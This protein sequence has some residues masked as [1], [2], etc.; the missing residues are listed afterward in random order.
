MEFK[1]KVQEEAYKKIEQWLPMTVGEDRMGKYG[2]DGFWFIEGS[3][4]VYVRVL[5]WGDEAI[6]RC[7]SWVTMDTKQT[8]ELMQYLLRTNSRILFGAFNLEDD[9]TITFEYSIV[10]STMDKNEFKTAIKAIA[11]IADKY[12]DE[13]VSK[14]G[15][16]T[17]VDK[18]REES[19]KK[20]P[21]EPPSKL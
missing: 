18:L 1:N 4:F 12:D 15:G 17:A 3:T 19:Q 16:K 20:A 8:P 21:Q 2:E 13:I 7:F 14:F 6:V 10:G 5:D 9:G 11:A